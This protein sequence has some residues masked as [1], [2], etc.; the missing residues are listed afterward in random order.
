LRR[1]FTDT[2]P[3]VQQQQTL[4]GALRGQLALLERSSDLGGSADYVSKFREF[5]YQETLFELFARQYEM[6]RMDESREGALIQVVDLAGVPELKSKPKRGLI[7]VGATLAA[8]LVL[9]A[10]VLARHSWQQSAQRPETAE[11]VARLR[12]AWRSK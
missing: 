12:L 4:L 9:V 7:A 1:N 6:A 8:L 3:E 11:K 10:F 2:A 5:K